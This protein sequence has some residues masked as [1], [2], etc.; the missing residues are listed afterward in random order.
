MAMVPTVATLRTAIADAVKLAMNSGAPLTVTTVHTRRRF[1]RDYDKF[2]SLFIRDDVGGDIP[3]DH[4][5]GWMITRKRAVEVEAEE[6]WRFH[7]LHTFTLYGYC[8]LQDETVTEETFID[9]IERI[10]DNLRLNLSVFGNTERVVPVCNHDLL[11]T[12]D[13]GDARCWYA[14]LSLTTEATEVKTLA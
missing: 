7:R 9:Q 3:A 2:V 11:E 4:I 1:W 13:L 10:A 5:N 8:G 6:R 14:E 12:Y